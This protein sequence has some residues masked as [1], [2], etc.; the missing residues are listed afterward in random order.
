MI[1][2]LNLLQQAGDLVLQCLWL[3]V[4]AEALLLHKPGHFL[5]S[6]TNPHS[7]RHE[8]I[9]LE[10]GAHEL[11]QCEL[12]DLCILVAR[13]ATASSKSGVDGGY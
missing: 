3:T 10:H 4:L 11:I 12:F 13:P 5:P 2:Y 9:D 1:M 6:I 8:R 7:W